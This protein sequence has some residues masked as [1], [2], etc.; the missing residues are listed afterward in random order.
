[1]T[2]VKK[3]AHLH[4]KKKTPRLFGGRRRGSTGNGAKA[5]GWKRREGVVVDP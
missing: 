3:K 5:K 4:F 1:L 2:E